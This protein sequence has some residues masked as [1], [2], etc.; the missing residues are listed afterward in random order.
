VN[1][2]GVGND[3]QYYAADRIERR[4]R[5]PQQS[6]QPHMLL[7]AAPTRLHERHGPDDLLAALAAIPLAWLNCCAASIAEHEFLPRTFPLRRFAT[8]YLQQLIRRKRGTVP[9]HKNWVGSLEFTPGERN[10]YINEEA[11]RQQG[12]LFFKGE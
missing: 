3:V 12:S 1:Q 10:E 11:T 4:E 6:Y 5:Q 8:K 7:H 2:Q 9:Y